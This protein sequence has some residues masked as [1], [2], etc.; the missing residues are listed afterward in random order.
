MALG[1]GKFTAQNKVLPG[2]YINFVS[3]NTADAQLSKRGIVTMPFELDW[4]IDG[5]VFTITR[6]EFQKDSKSIFGYDY[7]H[8]KM[9][10]LRD[11]FQNA[12]TLHAYKLNAGGEKASNAYATANHSGIRG[13]DLKIVVEQ[14]ADNESLFNVKTVIDMAVVDMQTVASAADLVANDYVTFKENAELALTASTPLAGGSNGTVDG[15][16][17]QEYLDKIESYTFNALGVVTTDETIKNMVAAFCKRLRDEVGLKFQAVLYRKPADYMGVVNVKNAVTD[18][19]WSEAALIYWTTGIIAGCAVNQSNQNKVYDGEFA[20][21]TDYTQTELTETIHAG[22]F[23]L[24]KVNDDIRVLADINS[25]VNTTDT[26]G[27]VFKDN[28]TIRVIDQLANDDALLFNTKYLGNVPGNDAGRV[29]LWSD[30]VKIREALQ[31]MGAIENF[32]DTDVVAEQGNSKKTVVITG[33][34]TVAHA[35]D[36]LY[37]TTTV[38]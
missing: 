23:T 33:S 17:Y 16:A 5:E 14:N 34:I 10:G 25:M 12:T 15:K 9:K 6:K 26:E 1:G 11:L 20:V 31:D 24:H 7:T 2:A 30:L 13:N 35:M 28:Q 27:D 4:G 32:K 8:E 38:E 21:E 29:S 18:T 22:E 3:L 36:K 37:M 19:S